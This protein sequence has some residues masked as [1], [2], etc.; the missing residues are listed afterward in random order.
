M[1]TYYYSIG[2]AMGRIYGRSDDVIARRTIQNRQ[3][4]GI[5]DSPVADNVYCSLSHNHLDLGPYR[6]YSP[7]VSPGG[8]G[9]G[10]TRSEKDFGKDTA[11]RSYFYYHTIFIPFGYVFH[12]ERTSRTCVNNLQ[13]HPSSS[14]PNARP[15]RA[16]MVKCHLAE[17]SDRRHVQCYEGEK[18]MEQTFYIASARRAPSNNVGFVG[19][20]ST[21]R[22]DSS[23]PRRRSVISLTRCAA[24]LN[25]EA[26]VR[27]PGFENPFEP[28][29]QPGMCT[30]WLL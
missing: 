22:C 15:E 20:R 8:K 21:A 4:S 28:D 24:A 16:L 29:P 18:K 11:V 6:S 5:C 27:R 3:L 23:T 10:C 2:G 17:A 25:F 9:G 13:R 14:L 30:A 12:I 7:R 1:Y 19:P 26:Q